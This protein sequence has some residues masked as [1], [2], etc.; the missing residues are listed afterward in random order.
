MPDDDLPVKSSPL[1]VS[2]CEFKL[3]CLLGVSLI[4]LIFSISVDLVS[5]KFA[6][7]PF[8]CSLLLKSRVFHHKILIF[9][10]EFPSFP[11]H[12]HLL[13]LF[14]LAFFRISLSFILFYL[15]YFISIYF[16]LLILFLF[17][18]SFYFLFPTSL[19]LYFNPFFFLCFCCSYY[20]LL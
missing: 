20:R 13:L 10:F 15:F 12:H 19:V 16:Y 18:I 7:K 2:H 3:S 5:F 1:G 4:V 6:W 14:T 8:F 17:S 9:L 11:F